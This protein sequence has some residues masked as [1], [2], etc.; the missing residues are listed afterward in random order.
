L[1][2]DALLDRCSSG[3]GEIQNF[4]FEQLKTLD[5]GGWFAPEFIGEPMASLQELL[6]LAEQS[7]TGLNLEIKP[8]PEREAETVEAV[9]LLLEQIQ[10]SC[11]IVISSFSKLAL[12][13]AKER[14]A[15]YQRGLL[16]DDIPLDWPEQL[17]EFGASAL[18][19]QDAHLDETA[20]A[21]LKAAGIPLLIY[22]VNSPERFLQ[23]MKEGVSAV[24]TDNPARLIAA[25]PVSD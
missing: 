8:T 16:V 7:G 11:P 2:H 19:A 1:F 21:E 6:E 15:D 10:P 20:L 24:F 3:S 22:T 13:A 23:L 14:L 5:C 25:I 4:D 9:A 17:E 18:H 12:R